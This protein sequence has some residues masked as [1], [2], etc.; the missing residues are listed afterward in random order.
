MNRQTVFAFVKHTLKLAL[1]AFIVVLIL[2]YFG[3]FTVKQSVVLAFLICVIYDLLTETRRAMQES[4]EPF[5]VWIEPKWRDLLRDY[6]LVREDEWDTLSSRLEALPQDQ[7]HVLRNGFHFTLLK[8]QPFDGLIYRDDRK[9]FRGEIDFRE[10]IEEIE[11]PMPDTKVEV[12]PTVFVKW[13]REGYDI[14]ITTPE[15]LGRSYHPRDDFG[16]ITVAT[17]PYAM[18]S[19]YTNRTSGSS[20]WETIDKPRKAALLKHGWKL[21]ERDDDLPDWPETLEHKYFYASVNGI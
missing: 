13:G 1:I 15:S 12:S 7:Y 10:R 2:R 11:L 3:D 5:S 4:F 20:L 21:N 17:L 9:V 6:K 18:F 14:G 16:L 19:A 8:P